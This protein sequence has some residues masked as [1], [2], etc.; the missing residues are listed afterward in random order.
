MKSKFQKDHPTNWPTWG[1]R[2]LTM[3]GQKVQTLGMGQC[4]GRDSECPGWGPGA[5]TGVVRAG[6]IKLGSSTCQ[7]PHENFDN[8]YDIYYSST[9]SKFSI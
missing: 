6:Q 3:G 8:L 7:R 1:S 9:I 2:R 5:P 4:R